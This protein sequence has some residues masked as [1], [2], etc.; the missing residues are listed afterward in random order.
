MGHE[1]PYVRQFFNH[2]FFHHI[3][4][5][6]GEPLSDPKRADTCQR[7]NFYQRR[8]AKAW[9]MAGGAQVIRNPYPWSFMDTCSPLLTAYKPRD[10]SE[11]GVRGLTGF[12]WAV[13]LFACTVYCGRGR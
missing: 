2:W 9:S 11:E 13:F 5:S 8:A 12:N 1:C 3:L 10:D 4:S 6:T 7:S